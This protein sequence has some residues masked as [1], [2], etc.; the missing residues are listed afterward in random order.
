MHDLVGVKDPSKVN[1]LDLTHSRLFTHR[2]EQLVPT[3]QDKK[4]HR[5]D[6]VSLGNIVHS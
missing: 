5:Y 1:E 3:S 4:Q 6:H 2:L